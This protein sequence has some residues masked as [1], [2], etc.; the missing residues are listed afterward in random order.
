MSRTAALESNGAGPSASFHT[1][2]DFIAF[3]A[4]DDDDGDGDDKSSQDVEENRETDLRTAH[5]QEN[6]NDA[7]SRETT[8]SKSNGKKRKVDDRVELEGKSKKEKKRELARGTPW[9]V[10]VDFD[11]CLNQ[12]DV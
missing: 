7:R 11:S 6:Q 4:F 10:D 1:S 8:S 12:A 3:D 5:V 2:E 9:C